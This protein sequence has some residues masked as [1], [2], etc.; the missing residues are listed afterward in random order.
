MYHPFWERLPFTNI[1]LSITPDILH[2]L[3][4]GISK[5]LIRWLIQFWGEE[6]DA[7]CSRLP[8]NHNAWHFY[9]GI[10]M[11]SNLTGQEHKDICRIIL[12]L[13]ADLTLPGNQSARLTRA[14]RVLLDFIYLSQY[15]VHATKSLNTLDDALCRFYEDKDIF[16][17]LGAR[18]HLNLPKL[19]SLTHY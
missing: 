3:H 16:I 18:Q 13:V 1:F 12:G 6:I 14:I 17:K 15:S 5:Y 9:K 19:H 11:L 10:T 7:C 8:P 4:Q 2:Q